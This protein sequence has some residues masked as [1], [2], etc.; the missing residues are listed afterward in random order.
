VEGSLLVTLDEVL[1]GSVRSVT[2][3]WTNPHTGATESQTLKVRIPPGVREDQLIRVAGRGEAGAGGGGAGDLYLRARLAA[4]P[5]LRAEG[6]DLYHDLD[7]APWEAVLGATVSVPTVDGQVS[8][9]IPP[10]ARS[11]QQ[12]RVRGRGL[13]RGTE[14]QRGDLFVVLSIQVPGELTTSE[15]TL[16]EKLARESHFDPRS[17]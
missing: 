12:L 1:H 3:R 5:E 4:H 8:L 16:W 2:L 10:G 13:P 14:S 7:L 9:R 15:R 17:K 6:S 11:G